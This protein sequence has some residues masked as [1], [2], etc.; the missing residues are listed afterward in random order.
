LSLA[1]PTTSSGSRA[2]SMQRGCPQASP[3]DRGGIPRRSAAAPHGRWCIRPGQAQ[4][5]ARVSSMTASPASAR[6]GRRLLR[7]GGSSA[8]PCGNARFTHRSTVHRRDREG[9]MQRD[10]RLMVALRSLTASHLLPCL[11]WGTSAVLILPLGSVPAP[12]RRLRAD[13]S[14]E[15]RASKP[16]RPGGRDVCGVPPMKRAHS[17]ALRSHPNGDD[18]NV[19]DAR[20]W[21]IQ[22]DVGN[23][24]IDGLGRIGRAALKIRSRPVAWMSSP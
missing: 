9:A 22:M 15:R 3:R 18:L 5:R 12:P 8:G 4:Y 23:V 13:R 21:G 7:C 20:P 17:S 16:R 6:R 24:A 1:R 11:S 19:R 14:R 2:G 10:G